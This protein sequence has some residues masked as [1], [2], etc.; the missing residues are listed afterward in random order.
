[1]YIVAGAYTLDKY[2][3]RYPEYK[4]VYLNV[5]DTNLDS[6]GILLSQSKKHKKFDKDKYYKQISKDRESIVSPPFD[7]RFS[8]LDSG[9]YQ[10]SICYLE[11]QYFDDYIDIYYKYLSEKSR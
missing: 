7:K 1:M 5:V 11:R 8:I 4:D 10:L 3:E 9:G 6:F 2:I